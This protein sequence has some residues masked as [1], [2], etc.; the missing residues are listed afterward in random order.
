MP[1]EVVGNY[2]RIFR[3]EPKFSSLE[4]GKCERSVLGEPILIAIFT[5][6]K[7]SPVSCPG[8]VT[9]SLKLCSRCAASPVK[10]LDVLDE[11]F[12]NKKEER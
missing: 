6:D 3:F 9:R 10:V 4:C 1:A 8:V 11:M 2:Y 5:E 12:Y 7:K